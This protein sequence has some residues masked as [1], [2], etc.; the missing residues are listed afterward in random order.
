MLLRVTRVQLGKDTGK[1][2]V[3]EYLGKETS[4]RTIGTWKL[5]LYPWE[6]V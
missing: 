3:P 4:A 5:E 1:L 2:Q 6:R